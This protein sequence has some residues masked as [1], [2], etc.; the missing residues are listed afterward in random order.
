MTSDNLENLVRIGRLKKEPPRADELVGLK[1]SA[2]SRLD[3]AERPN[4]VI[5]NRSEW[6][7]GASVAIAFSSSTSTRL[8]SGSAGVG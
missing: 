2:V 1:S 6:R 4:L 8:F 7:H 3:D 5:E